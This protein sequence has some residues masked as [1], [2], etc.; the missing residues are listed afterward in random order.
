MMGVRIPVQKKS[1]SAK[2]AT[3]VASLAGREDW[4][5]VRIIQ[6]VDEYEAEPIFFKSNL[7]FN[8]VKSEG[9]MHIPADCTGVTA[10]EIV[11]VYLL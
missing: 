3:N 10:G 2:V 7:I 9:L 5:P 11:R 1:I 6:K 8:L 4:I